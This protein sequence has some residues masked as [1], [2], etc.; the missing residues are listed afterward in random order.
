MSSWVSAADFTH[1]WAPCSSPLP[2]PPPPQ[3]NQAQ[4]N[5][6]AQTFHWFS[7]T[8]HRGEST[9]R[10]KLSEVVERFRHICQ[11]LS[12]QIF[13]PVF[14]LRRCSVGTC[15][16][17]KQDNLV[18][19]TTMGLFSRDWQTRGGNVILQSVGEV[20]FA[21][22]ESSREVRINDMQ[23]CKARTTHFSGW[24]SRKSCRPPRHQIEFLI[25][26]FCFTWM[27]D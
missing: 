19:L 7:D 11:I 8:K 22:R 4:V 14:Q 3:R 12:R 27:K 2:H 1:V 16:S 9:R 21:Q 18:R 20:H 5:H 13:G 10:A 26:A 24:G 25:L 15:T 17:L 23:V 6:R